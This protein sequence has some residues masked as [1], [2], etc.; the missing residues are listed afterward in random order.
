MLTGVGDRA[1]T[2]RA[3]RHAR[4]RHGWPAG[5]AAWALGFLGVAA[6]C[7]VLFTL[8]LS[9]SL[10]SPFNS[11]GAANVLQAQA[12]LHGNPL[13]RGWWTSDVSFYTTELPE[14]ALIVAIR[15]ISPDVVHLCGALTCTLTLLL[16]ALL[17]RGRDRGRAGL[18]RAGITLGIMLAPS[19]LGGTEVFLE[20]PDHA[21]TAVP[22]LALLLLLD[23]A[24]RRWYVL[25]AAGALLALTQLADELSLVAATI[26]I[27]VVCAGRMLMAVGPRRRH[28]VAVPGEPTAGSGLGAGHGRE[29]RYD[30][31]LLTASLASAVAGRLAQL[32]IRSL[33]G[34]DLRSMPNGLVVPLGRVPGNARVLWQS[35][36]LLFGANH[37]GTPHTPV[38]IAG[39]LPLVLLADL[40]LIGLA[41][42]VAGFAAGVAALVSGRADRVTGVLVVAIGGTLAAGVISP[43]MRSL[44]N[45]H[46]VAIL[47]PLGA[48]LAGRTLPPLAGR[49][50]PPLAGRTLPPLA[51]RTL[52]PLAR[53]LASSR[54]RPGRLASAALVGWLALALAEL[55]YAATW[56]AN[57]PQGRAVAAWLVGHHEREGLAGYWQA[58]ATTVESG[59][60]VLVAPVLGQATEV[61]RWEASASWY[62]PSSHRA[63][64]VIAVPG[65]VAKAGALTVAQARD[66]FGPPAARYS[67][68][69]EIILTYRY[70]LL[71][72]LGGRAFPGRP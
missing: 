44:A 24:A 37:P 63:T 7:A 20:N 9:Q 61:Q 57:P 40:H 35:L 62:R 5:R 58:D 54:A 41:L 18:Y 3:A 71:A 31:M 10:T 21:G 32:A 36:L 46:E 51:G 56:P 13:L 14:Y 30:A 67:V 29:F 47:L 26:P 25:L 45:A 28:P 6:A 65:R 4:R 19:I 1:E 53:R 38:A 48:A 17:A 34:F 39:H 72:R 23:R 43:L 59:G 52:S 69:G 42:A 12:M 8:Y 16:A 33:G 70:N 22:V 50:L 49:T 27:A 11:D 66:R 64:F 60:R 68:D 2:A 15:G 55:C